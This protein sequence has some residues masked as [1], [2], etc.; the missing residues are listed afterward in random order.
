MVNKCIQSGKVYRREVIDVVTPGGVKR[1]LGGTIAPI[2]LAPE[3]GA[4]GA[5]CL[6]TDITEVMQLR[7][8]VALK[9]NLESLGE[10]SAGHAHEF[11][12]AIATLHG[13]AQLL[14][15]LKLDEAG[16]TATSSLLNEVRNLSEMVTAFLNF[17]RPQ[18]LELDN[19]SLIDLLQ[20]CAADL[21]SLFDERHVELR[22]DK[23]AVEQDIV[24]RAD[25]RMLRQ[26]LLNLL[27]NAVEA[28]S[29]K[30]LERRVAVVTSVQ[31][32]D[33]GEWAVVEISDSGEGIPAADLERIFIPFF[34][35]K[36][37]GHGV[38]LALAHRVVTQHG[39]R[40][41]ATNSATQDGATFRMQLPL[42]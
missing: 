21:R 23:S 27:R 30:A 11:K 12:N 2:E 16:Q 19:V 25:E 18:P 5:L 3:L 14:Q 37:S 9:Q 33:T 6:L 20:D 7:E 41:T 13:Y 36:A 39:G 8:Q 24:V 40:L 28:I 4:R 26:T 17:A 10:M 31:R 29:D 35:T 32:D 22:L 34:T 1:Q 15:N 42:S 38:G